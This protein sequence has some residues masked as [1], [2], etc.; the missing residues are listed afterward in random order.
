MSTLLKRRS[1]LASTNHPE[2]GGEIAQDELVSLV[3]KADEAVTEPL[4]FATA[5]QIG[6][7]QLSMVIAI[8]FTYEAGNGREN[9]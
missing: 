2:H 5:A 1:R 4:E 9:R 6:T 3:R 7:A 8:Y